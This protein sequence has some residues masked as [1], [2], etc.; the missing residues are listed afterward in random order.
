MMDSTE[1]R[2]S[3]LE[4]IGETESV[5]TSNSTQT[6]TGSTAVVSS[7]RQTDSAPPISGKVPTY[8][9]VLDITCILLSLPVLLPVSLLI[10]LVIKIGS[11]GPVLFKQERVGFL[12]RRF[13]I[14]KF[15]SM[16][17]GVDTVVHQEYSSRL[18]GSNLPMTKLDTKGDSRLI[19]LGWLLRASGLDELPQ[20]I[21]V[22]RGEMSLVG[23]RPCILCEY[24]KYLS[25]QKERFITLPGLTGLW[26]VSGKNRTTFVEM[27]RLDIEYAR[28]PNLRWD[29]EIMWK[30]F[31]A[32][33]SQ[34]QD[35]QGQ[36]KSVERPSQNQ[37][38]ATIQSA[39]GKAAA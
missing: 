28:H 35:T 33:T 23:P 26:Q 14:F 3:G 36:R 37:L 31:S 13:M 16:V 34:I 18:I 30:T 1:V 29:L 25:W 4:T 7:F 5:S 11:R 2:Q 24:E 39:S 8:K 6:I 22:L 21:N 10:A 27:I 20:L 38:G 15:R 19:P 9:R 12:G 32:L 17:A